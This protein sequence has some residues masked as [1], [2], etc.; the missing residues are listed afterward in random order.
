MDSYRRKI[1]RLYQ[2]LPEDGKSIRRDTLLWWREGLAEEGCSTEAINQSI[3]A[4]NGYLEYMGT[5]EFQVTD[6]LESIGELQPELT[7]SE[8]LRLL[9]AARA[10]GRKQAYLLV[11]VFGN[12]DLPIQELAHLTVETARAGMMTVSYKCSTE[13][14]RFPGC[15]CRELLEYAE[16]RGIPSGPI[17]LT[18]TEKL[19]DRTNVTLSIRRLCATAQVPEEK[20]NPRCLRKMYQATRESIERSIAL[21]VEQAQSRLL[22]EE[23]L[24]IGWDK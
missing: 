15:V 10:L 2:A 3:I 12:S 18:R 16:R 24:T 6:K 7:R 21:L 1:R 14:I 17:F 5:R 23:Q 13:I 11:K 8:Y 20:G 9:S 22:E 19:M 4:A